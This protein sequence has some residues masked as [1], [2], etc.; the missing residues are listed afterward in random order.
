M[1]A[2]TTDSEMK[3]WGNSN[4]ADGQLYHWQTGP[5]N[6]WIKRDKSDWLIAETKQAADKNT[7]NFQPASNE[8]GELKWMRWSFRT[9]DTTGATLDRFTINRDQG[10]IRPMLCQAHA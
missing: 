8:P 3:Q 1:K 4:Y 7:T 9:T 6:L 2:D 10:K 5:L